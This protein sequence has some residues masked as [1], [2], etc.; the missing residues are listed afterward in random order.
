MDRIGQT[1][2]ANNRANEDFVFNCRIGAVQ[3][4]VVGDFAQSDYEPIDA[5]TTNA[6]QLLTSDSSIIEAAGKSIP[7]LL[8]QLATKLNARLLS[9]ADKYK[10]KFQSVAMFA[11]ISDT[12]LFYLPIGDCRLSVYTGKSLLLLNG[13][14]W[15]DPS[16][17]RLPML[18]EPGQE[19]FKGSE[20][21]PDRALG[22]SPDLDVSSDHVR[23]C[24]LNERD[25]VL[26]YSDGVDK[27]VSPVRLLQ[28]IQ[29]HASDAA[30]QALSE[31]IIEEVRL[32]H[33]NDDRTLLIFAGPHLKQED[34]AMAESARQIE[35][36]SASMVSA[37]DRIS[38]LENSSIHLKASVDNVAK[39]IN[40][41]PDQLRSSSG[42]TDG[43]GPHS[44]KTILE[45]LGDIQHRVKNIE[46]SRGGHKGNEPSNK[47][48][49]QKKETS[50]APPPPEPTPHDSALTSASEVS[51]LVRV[52]PNAPFREGILRITTGFFELV[53]NTSYQGAGAICLIPRKAVRP[54]WLT[55]AYLYLRLDKEPPKENQTA[56]SIQ[57]WIKARFEE[58]G[59]AAANL[60]PGTLD[61]L[62]TQH[63]KLRDKRRGIQ[64]L[65]LTDN[66]LIKQEKALA[67]KT[68]GSQQSTP[69]EEGGRQVFNPNEESKQDKILKYVLLA[70]IGLAV[71]IVPTTIYKVWFSEP[72][73]NASQGPVIS[74]PAPEPVTLDYG[75]DGRALYSLKRGGRPEQ[76][77][78]RIAIGKELAFRNALTQQQF[79]SREQLIKHIEDKAGDFVVRSSEPDFVTGNFSALDLVAADVNNQPTTGTERCQRFLARVNKDELRARDKNELKDLQELNPGLK[80]GELKAGDRL[81]VRGTKR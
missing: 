21:D 78:Y 15:V 30:V 12:D 23:H 79:S 34:Q 65:W 50:N 76:I 35:K 81:V 16:G 38:L 73:T 40:Q 24:P 56:D 71:I 62:R 33:G 60:P 58:A 28:L 53:D 5:A 44:L 66:G 41:L 42:G 39:Q 55:A 46:N 37:L 7:L 2:V 1:T 26:L 48:N 18:V 20:A 75:A 64:R 63:W 72:T 22:I 49:Q 45:K 67:E 77:D 43:V 31:K 47:S 68:F 74:S 57:E 29:E 8:S 13:S 80:C 25:L 3:L 4:L 11:A 14:I 61:S 70:L 27:F 36:M 52:N 59:T 32:E 69:P 10:A 17:N 51:D 6:L 9:F 54:G 19:V